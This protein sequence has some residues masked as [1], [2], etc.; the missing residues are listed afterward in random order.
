MIL[1]ALRFA[2][3]SLA[4]PQKHLQLDHTYLSSVS[5]DSITYSQPDRKLGILCMKY[6]AGLGGVNRLPNEASL[7]ELIMKISE[8][9]G[10]YCMLTCGHL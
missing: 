2:A 1:G 8:G 7:P 3:H 9:Q 4:Q 6:F 5:N 10:N